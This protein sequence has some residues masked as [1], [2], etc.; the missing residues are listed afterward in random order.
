MSPVQSGPQRHALATPTLQMA[1]MRKPD[2]RSPGENQVCLPLPWRSSHF[3][4]LRCKLFPC[5]ESKEHEEGG[6]SVQIPVTRA[7]REAMESDP[8]RERRWCPLTEAVS[9]KADGMG[10]GYRGQVRQLNL[11]RAQSPE[12]RVD[13]KCCQQI[14]LEPGKR[15]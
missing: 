2:A 1:H 10:A 3:L 4:Q 12:A 8:N 7:P 11:P 14:F 5:S 13:P 15:H 9:S 6:W